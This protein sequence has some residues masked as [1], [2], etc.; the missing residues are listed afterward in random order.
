[1]DRLYLVGAAALVAGGAGY[2]VGVLTPYPGRSFS[3]TAL[4][5]GIALVVVARTHREGSA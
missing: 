3:V 4:M 5:V 1:M 2:A